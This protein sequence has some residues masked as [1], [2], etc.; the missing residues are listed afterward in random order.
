MYVDQV[1]VL[2]QKLTRG[3]RVSRPYVQPSLDA[4]VQEVSL[5]ESR[6]SF[7]VTACLQQR[8]RKRCV[9][10]LMVWVKLENALTLIDRFVVT[11]CPVEHICV[12]ALKI[13]RHGFRH[14]YVVTNPDTLINSPLLREQQRQVLSSVWIVGIEIDGPPKSDLSFVPS[15]RLHQRMPQGCKRFRGSWVEAHGLL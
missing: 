15:A 12:K 2:V 14:R 4:R 8:V 7:L 13:Y 5:G 11:V 1:R 3:G 6:L 10:R 9:G